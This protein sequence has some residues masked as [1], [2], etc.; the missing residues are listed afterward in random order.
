VVLNTND[1][2]KVAALLMP[3]TYQRLPKD[4]NEAVERQ[5]TLLKK[6]SLSEEA[7]QQ[8]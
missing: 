4:L 6:S 8:V 1:Y 3:S 5:T 2:E 7:I